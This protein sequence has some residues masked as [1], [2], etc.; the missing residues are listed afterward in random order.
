[1]SVCRPRQDSDFEE[2]PNVDST[3]SKQPRSGETVSPSQLQQAG[4]NKAI[5][6]AKLWARKFGAKELGATWMKLLV[7]EFKKDYLTKVCF[8]LLLEKE[9]TLFVCVLIYDLYS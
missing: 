3:A 8:Q 5:A 1:M 6:E 2:T 7:P 4:E 9:P